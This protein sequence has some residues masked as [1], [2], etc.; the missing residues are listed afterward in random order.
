[1]ADKDKKSFE[2]IPND[3]LQFTRK[4]GESIEHYMARMDFAKLSIFPIDEKNLVNM[5]GNKDGILTTDEALE[6]LNNSPLKDALPAADRKSMLADIEAAQKAEKP[7]VT[8]D[9]LT[10]DLEETLT[11]IK[12]Q[13]NP[14]KD[15]K[16]E[17]VEVEA[18]KGNIPDDVLKLLDINGDNKVSKGE[19]SFYKMKQ[20]MGIP[21][22]PQD[23]LPKKPADKPE[24][25]QENKPQGPVKRGGTRL[26]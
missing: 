1:M 25:K 12:V 15:G 6:A 23:D 18:V 16:V 13:K 22:K 17:P 2:I 11:I 24:N 4:E 7:L 8:V 9:E 26:V 5:D 10:K 3:G 19:A 21:E 20:A 14:V